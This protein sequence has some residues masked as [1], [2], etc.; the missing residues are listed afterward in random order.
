MGSERSSHP[1]VVLKPLPSAPVLPRYEVKVQLP[2][3]ITILD[4][5]ATFSVCGK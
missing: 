4:R 3:V 5:E 2:P 1:R